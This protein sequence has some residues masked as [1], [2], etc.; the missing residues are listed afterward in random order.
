MRTLTSLVFTLLIGAAAAGAAPLPPGLLGTSYS[1]HDGFVRAREHLE[2]LWRTGF[3]LVTFVPGHAYV[4]LDRIDFTRS[5]DPARLEEA[6]RLALARG[7]T[8]VVKPHLEPGMYKGMDPARTDN[9]SW[10]VACPW[11]GW[12]DVDPLSPAYADGV[13]RR[14]LST[15]ARAIRAASRNRRLPPVR[16]DLGSELM[17][18]VV[19]KPE[20]W[21]GLLEVARRELA[22]QGL[23]GQVLLSHNFSHHL[24][25]A[26]DE[27]LRMSPQ[28]RLILGR[29]VGAL[30]A[31]AISQYMNLTVAAPRNRGDRLPTPGEIADA[32]MRHERAFVRDILV[33]QLGLAATRIPVLHVGEFGIGSGGLAH[34]NLWD[35]R[36]EGDAA[37][38]LAI[39]SEQGFRGLI[40]YLA[41]PQAPDGRRCRT[42]V[43]WTT[44]RHFD[45]FGWMDKS[46]AVPG[47]ARVVSAALTGAPAATGP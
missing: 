32:L 5:P 23:T 43:L 19:E 1:D 25:I 37:R 18:S 38:R 24:M 35:G 11:R 6:I 21:V 27:V 31:I 4:G 3:R 40:A 26:E 34:P 22:A 44:G 39:E 17:N 14:T 41:R 28:R 46:N 36:P 2:L 42:A 30:D 9:P 15:I 20:R 16:F 10:R 29:Y 12:F 13:V 45:I 7:F 47:A 33:A 8:V